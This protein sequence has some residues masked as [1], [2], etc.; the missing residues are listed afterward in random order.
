MIRL[1]LRASLNQGNF[2]HTL[3]SSVVAHC[4]KEYIG[5]SYCLL[6]TKAVLLIP[7]QHCSKSH[8]SPAGM[9]WH[10]NRCIPS[11]CE[12]CEHTCSCAVRRIGHIYNPIQFQFPIAP[13]KQHALHNL[14]VQR[15]DALPIPPPFNMVTDGMKQL[16]TETSPV[17]PSFAHSTGLEQCR[18]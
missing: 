1:S 8:Q 15:G 4:F 3:H 12:R 11:K 13:T 2:E 9:V 7:T 16:I 14:P 17:H 10:S 18:R 6:I 5:M